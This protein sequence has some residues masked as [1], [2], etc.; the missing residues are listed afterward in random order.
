MTVM[1]VETTGWTSAPFPTR[2]TVVRMSA[3]E[4]GEKILQQI[5]STTAEILEHEAK[6]G[7]LR[8]VRKSLCEAARSEGVS[9]R[10]LADG[11][12]IS[13]V[14]VYKILR[15]DKDSVKASA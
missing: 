10:A 6:A 15:G 12:Q 13:E 2:G 7:D 5:Q 1:R 11:M 4:Q 8:K 9:Y 14:A 3:S